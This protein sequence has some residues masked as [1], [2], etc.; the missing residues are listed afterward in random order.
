[1]IG[2]VNLE[3]LVFVDETGSN[4]AMTRRYAR[5]LKG[6]RVYGDCPEQRRSNITLVG[7]IAQEGMIAAIASSESSILLT[8]LPRTSV[9]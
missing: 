7:A 6:T 8:F 4:L 2:E 5:S 9:S 3:D 1:M